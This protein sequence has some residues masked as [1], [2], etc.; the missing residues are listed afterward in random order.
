[1]SLRSVATWSRGTPLEFIWYSLEEA[2]TLLLTLERAAATFAAS[3]HLAGV[4]AVEREIELLRRKLAEE[5]GPE[6]DAGE[7]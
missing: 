3:D 5:G 1:M 4:E 6:G 2:A 7:R